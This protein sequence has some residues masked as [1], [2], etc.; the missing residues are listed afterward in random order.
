MFNQIYISLVT[1]CLAACTTFMS[2]PLQRSEKL[3]QEELEL[4]LKSDKPIYI[5]G[6]RIYR[7]REI[8]QKARISSKPEPR[9]TADARKNRVEGV[10]E[11]SLI[12]TS[13]G[14]VKVLHARKKL[15][16][17]LTEQA[18]KAAKKI[19]FHPATVDGKAVSTFLIAHYNFAL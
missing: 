8:H 2:M 17:G 1:L 14:K 7:P 13:A 18:L 9:Y 10:V 4:L 6:E 11:I 16:D 12:V 5:D 15:P 19:K 3:S